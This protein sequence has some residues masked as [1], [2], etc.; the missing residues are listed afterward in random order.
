MLTFM[1]SRSR[2]PPPAEKTPKNQGLAR[3]T[4]RQQRSLDKIELMF[5]AAMRLIQESDVATLTT[6]AVAARAGVS[7]GTLYQYFDGKQA[8]LDALV[9][10][11]LG[12]MSQAILDAAKVAPA[13]AAPGDK[14]R[15][16]VRAALGAYGGRGRVHRR[17][18]EHALTQTSGS[19]LSPLFAQLTKD[20]SSK[21]IAVP[22]ETPRPLTPAQAFVLTHSI[23]GVL[24]TMAASDNAPPLR[25]VEDALVQLAIAYLAAVR[26]D[27][28]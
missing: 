12:V 2:P 18:I 20:F 24:R 9:Q 7:I 26:S 13:E 22:G 19:R 23:A 3:R 1:N 8:L 25:E 17:L 21:G 27:S 4:P 14:I 16:I 10:R 15:R 6:N 11:E 28:E 5:E